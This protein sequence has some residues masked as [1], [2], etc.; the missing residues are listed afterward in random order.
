MPHTI[1]LVLCHIFEA[2]QK[3]VCTFQFSF[4]HHLSFTQIFPIPGAAMQARLFLYDSLLLKLATCREAGYGA[5]HLRFSA[6]PVILTV[7]KL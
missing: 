3:G 1:Y 5:G 6:L 4:R 7:R 2:S